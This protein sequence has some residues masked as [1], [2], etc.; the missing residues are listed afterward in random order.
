MTDLHFLLPSFNAPADSNPAAQAL[1]AIENAHLTTSDLLAL[2]TWEVAKRTGLSVT[3]V[4]NLV[5][6]IANKLCADL[7]GEDDS[8]VYRG[9]D[10]GGRE[11]NDQKATGVKS[12]GLLLRERWSM[13]STLDDALDEAIG[14]GFPVG[15]VTEITGESGA[16]KTQLLLSLLLSVQ[17]APSKGGISKF[18]VYIST[19]APLPTSRLFQILTTHPRFISNADDETTKR[20]SLSNIHTL[21]TPDLESQEHILRYQLPIAIKRYNVGLVVI[22]SIT[23][24]FR[25]EFEKGK[26]G[27]GSGGVTDGSNRE[28]APGMARRTA[29]LLSLGS[30]LRDLASRENIAVVV[31]NQVADRFTSSMNSGMDTALQTS[32]LPSSSAYAGAGGPAGSQYPQSQPPQQDV[33]SAH[34]QQNDPT[35]TLDHQALFFTGWGDDTGSEGDQQ[36][37][38]SNMK[39]PSLGLVWTNQIAARIALLKDGGVGRSV[40]G[41]STGG[42]KRTFKLV[43]APWAAPT[44]VGFEICASGLRGL[45]SS[46]SLNE[47]EHDNDNNDD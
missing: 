39:T 12:T 43:F 6:R 2:D 32:T 16:G 35:L 7:E 36:T 44:S 33:H 20:P 21:R 4:K 34:Q 8:E 26:R 46:K 45:A 25:A 24:N 14:G 30:L 47:A 15:Y 19:E 31:A 38:G 18:A 29:Q 11:G 1:A 3:V 40:G 37:T 27:G 5:E 10:G 9:G 22:D 41:L 13:I 17:M 28:S 42:T 23:A